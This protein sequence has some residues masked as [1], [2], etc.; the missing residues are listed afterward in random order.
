MTYKQIYEFSEKYIKK[1]E[2][3]ECYGI[4]VRTDFD[5]GKLVMVDA[6][7]PMNN[8]RYDVLDESFNNNKPNRFG[9]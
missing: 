3:N 8:N 7:G 9:F 1:H 5:K 2:H 4:S 6:L